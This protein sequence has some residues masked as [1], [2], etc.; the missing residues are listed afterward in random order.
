MYHSI[1]L[2]QHHE[3]IKK[4]LEKKIN[5]KIYSGSRSLIE[6][7]KYVRKI[8]KNDEIII[9]TFRHDFR[10]IAVITA[11]FIFGKNINVGIHCA[12]QFLGREYIGLRKYLKIK[13]KSLKNIFK[14]FLFIVINYL[15]TWYLKKMAKPFGYISEIN[16]LFLK[17][18]IEISDLSKYISDPDSNFE[19]Y[20]GFDSDEKL[21]IYGRL[22]DQRIS[23]EKLKKLIKIVSDSEVELNVLVDSM[24]DIPKIIQESKKIKI[25]VEKGYSYEVLGKYIASCDYIVDITNEAKIRRGMNFEQYGKT[26]MSGM[27]LDSVIYNK[28]IIK[29]N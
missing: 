2:T 21:L 28:K 13:E 16:K 12:N 18:K 22:D 8:E 11:G 3:V 27:N 24:S 1:E 14:Y 10:T 25:Y 20:R 4:Y 15:I 23:F 26:I 9:N 17:E 5:I 19:I 29:I 6:V 7:I